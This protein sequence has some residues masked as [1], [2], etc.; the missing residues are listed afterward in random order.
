MKRSN[1]LNVPL[2]AIVFDMDGLM[3]DTEPLS[4]RAWE[5]VLRPFGVRLADAVYGRMIGHRTGEAVKL[6]LDA[7][8]LPLTAE[9][10]M[11]R[12]A[13]VLEEIL[14]DELPVMPGLMALQAEISR[15]SLPWAVATSSSRRHAENLLLRLGLLNDCHALVGGDEVVHGK[16]AP[17]I[18]LLAAQRL[19]VPAHQCL[20]LEDSSPG[21]QAATQAGMVT[22][23]VPN[24]QT[25]TAEFA[26]AHHI[27]PSLLQVAENL[28]ILLQETPKPIS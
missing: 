11:N 7:Y 6:L 8:D 20:A 10:I 21:C 16:P 19:G 12:K 25:K 3:V 23:A 24:G 22:I 27:Y 18:Y 14:A 13:A 2:R 1:G 9:E 17:D 26:C 15:R 28:D 5:H 4:R